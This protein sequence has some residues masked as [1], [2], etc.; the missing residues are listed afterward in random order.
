MIKGAR[1]EGIYTP[2]ST[3]GTIIYPF[4][5]GGT[6]WG[7]LSFDAARNVVFVNTSSVPVTTRVAFPK[8][9]RRID[10]GP[11]P[12]GFARTGRHGQDP[13]FSDL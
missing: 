3:Q 11:F 12:N 10:G 7:G 2:P 8:S 5:G 9:S 13:R 1:N 4:T 6:N